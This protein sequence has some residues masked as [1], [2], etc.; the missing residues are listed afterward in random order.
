MA[1]AIIPRMLEYLKVPVRAE[2]GPWNH[3]WP[4]DGTPGPNYE[5]R[6]NAVR[7]WDHWLKGKDTGIL[8]EPRFLFFLRYPHPPDTKLETVPGHWQQEDWPIKRTQWTSWYLG[9]SRNLQKQ[10]GGAAE[11][12]KYVSSCGIEAGFWW[13]ELTPDMRG[14]DACSLIFDSEPVAKT[15]DIIGQPKIKL[16]VKSPV[17]V[18]HWI[19]R[20]EDIHPDGTVS[21]V[22]GA[23]INGSQRDSRLN[24]EP[25]EPGM[26]YSIEFEM[27]FTTWRFEGGHRIRLSIS[28]SQWPML[29]PTPYSMD[30]QIEIGPN[31]V[32]TL[33]IL[34][35]EKNIVSDLPKPE[36]Q[37]ERSDA[38]D[39]SYNWPGKLEVQKDLLTSTTKVTWSGEYT[40][41]LPESI[42]QY[43]QTFT[44]QTNDQD[45]AY[46]KF[47]AEG[48]DNITFT[49]GRKLELRTWIKIQSDA[50]DFHVEV[51]RRISE[52]RQADPRTHLER[53]VPT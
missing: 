19:A 32:L 21:L 11:S 39:L 24:P 12:L 45:P 5:W 8:K 46:S 3:S 38:K 43:F 36:P 10:P 16:T 41:Q 23:A 34:E 29:W 40:I 37:E 6:Y 30:T 53:I 52:T 51:T 2:L 26:P 1:I 49:S 13:G 33:P 42:L 28:N 50:D 7:W 15:S 31:T 22:A 25:L 9:N 48:G 35:Y 47:E 4:N 17:P 44:H 14:A 20:L 27:H 18:A